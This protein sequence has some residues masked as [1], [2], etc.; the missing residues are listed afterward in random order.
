LS[1]S[2][3]AGPNG[4]SVEVGGGHAS[5]SVGDSDSSTT[6]NHAS[7]GECVVVIHGPSK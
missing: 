1:G 7:S 3:S 2:S 4:V 5:S 6:A